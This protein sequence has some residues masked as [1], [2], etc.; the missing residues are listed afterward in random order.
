MLHQLAL[1]LFALFF[2][3]SINAGMLCSFLCIPLKMPPSNFHLLSSA[4]SNSL[5]RFRPNIGELRTK[6]TDFNKLYPLIYFSPIFH[7]YLP[8]ITFND[9]SASN[10]YCSIAQTFSSSIFE[11]NMLEKWPSFFKNFNL[12]YKNWKLHLKIIGSDEKSAKFTDIFVMDV[13]VYEYRVILFKAQI[14]IERWIDNSI[15]IFERKIKRTAKS[16][17]DIKGM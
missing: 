13:D 5:M 9:H 1:T 8:G 7:Y 2:R 17:R 4:I 15:G 11:F 16:N 14:K 10:I 12:T 3:I 6:C